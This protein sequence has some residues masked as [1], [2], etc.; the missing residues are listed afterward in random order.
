MGDR[1]DIDKSYG[2]AFVLDRS[3][4]TRLFDLCDQR[5]S[6]LGG[7]AKYSLETGL[8]NGTHVVLT[9]IDQLLAQDNTVRNPIVSL[10]ISIGT[11][12]DA[13]SRAHVGMAFDN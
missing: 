2:V 4:L 13:T 3:K 10:K 11:A 6:E 1:V 12:K 5:F 8:K 7:D 9:S